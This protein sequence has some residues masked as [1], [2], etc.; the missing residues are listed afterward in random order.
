[1]EWRP[2]RPTDREAL[3]RFECTTRPEKSAETKWHVVHPR[4]WEYEVQAAIRD[5]RPPF[6][7]NDERVYVLEDSEGLA[8]VCHLRELDGPAHVELQEIGVALRY[9]GRG[10]EVAWR[11]VNHLL[12]EVT[13]R[14]LGESI[15]ADPIN[16]VLVQAM[17]W[18]EN[19][20]SLALARRLGME[21]VSVGSPG[22]LRW[23]M[24][25]LVGGVDEPAG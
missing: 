12:D 2:C 20:G 19:R 16:E 14:A 13:D 9:R 23:E 3:T 8:A 6:R 11:A 25:L 4:E 5:L 18:H 1:M 7:E 24:V 17:I 10:G 15:E 21:P 22:V